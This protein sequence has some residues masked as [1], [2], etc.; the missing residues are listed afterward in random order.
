VDP[1]GG[2]TAW[3]FAGSY[4]FHPADREGPDER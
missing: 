4:S 1:N 3:W 2:I